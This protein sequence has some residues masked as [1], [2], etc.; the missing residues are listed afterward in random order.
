TGLGLAAVR[1]QR[2]EV[3]GHTG[4]GCRTAS[5]P[6]AQFLAS[7]GVRSRADIYYKLERSG[8][9]RTTE[10]G[11]LRGEFRRHFDRVVRLLHLRYRRGAGVR[12]VVL[13]GRSEERRV[14]E[15][16]R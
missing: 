5:M 2:S 8:E 3:G 15:E 11:H 1:A 10:E 7:R 4:A 6:S 14:G 13:P 16:C 12:N 9:G